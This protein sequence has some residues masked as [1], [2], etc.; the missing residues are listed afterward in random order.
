MSIQAD[1]EF[2]IVSPTA[3][4]QYLAKLPNGVI[5]EVTIRLGTGFFDEGKLCVK[6]KD[7]DDLELGC[8]IFAD[9]RWSKKC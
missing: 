9:W 7:D 5:R 3:P 4:G 6:C 2:P 1:V 8:L